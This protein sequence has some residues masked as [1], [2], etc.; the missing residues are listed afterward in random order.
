MKDTSASLSQCIV[1]LVYW[2]C[3]IHFATWFIPTFENGFSYPQPLDFLILA[4]FPIGAFHAAKFARQR[5]VFE[6]YGCLASSVFWFSYTFTSRYSYLIA[7][8]VTVLLAAACRG[9]AMLRPRWNNWRRFPPGSCR[10][11]GYDLTGNESG[12]CPECGSSA[13]PDIR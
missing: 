13:K 4:L 11:C 1:T 6:V 9:A 8:V 12:V 10:H 7:C 2:F 3:P 5:V